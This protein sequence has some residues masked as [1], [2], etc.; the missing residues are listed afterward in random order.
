MRKRI[1]LMVLSVAM[2]AV[3]GVLLAQEDA[4]QVQ[5]RVD[6]QVRVVNLKYYAA[7]EMSNVL[8][9]LSQDEEIQV[10]V[11]ENANRLILRA[12]ERQMSQL[13]ALIEQLDVPIASAPESQSLLCRVYMV[14]L[15]AQH[16]DR[17]PFKAELRVGRPGVSLQQLLKAGEGKEFE[18]DAFH[19]GEPAADGV[20]QIKI[21]GR[22]ASIE[23]LTQVLDMVPPGGIAS[24]ELLEKTSDLV[25]PAAQVSSLPDQVR[26]HIHKFLGAEVQTVGYWFGTMSS[27]GQVSP[28]IGPWELKLILKPTETTTFH[29]EVEVT[30][31]RGDT[32][33]CVL[34]NTLQGRVGKPIIIGYNRQVDNVRTMGAM[35]ILLDGDTAAAGESQTKTP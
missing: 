6:V 19:D 25:V 24:M 7:N 11:D 14:E 28:P 8:Q 12:P 13:V 27:P 26:Q 22:T 29:L 3:P 5:D 4:A 21:E 16:A 15:P 9:A 31:M 20:H 10:I 30:E 34:E 1:M 35:V 2:L 32:V 33:W 17:K 18:I 23:I